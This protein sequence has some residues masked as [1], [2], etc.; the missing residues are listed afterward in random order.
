M[1]LHRLLNRHSGDLPKPLETVRDKL[2]NPIHDQ[3]NVVVNANTTRDELEQA[4][5]NR[6][7]V[8]DTLQE[9]R[10]HVRA[11]HKNPIGGNQT[12]TFKR[13]ASASGDI[14]GNPLSG[15][16]GKLERGE[17]LLSAILAK[18]GKS[19]GKVLSL[20]SATP[21]GISTIEVTF[22][23]TP[24]YRTLANALKQQGTSL[25]ELVR[26]G[27]HARAS[28]RNADHAHLQTALF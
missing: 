20:I 18:G 5:I 15:W 21:K 13:Y 14:P 4:P 10:F 22:D 24:D 3:Y 17:A 6:M 19:S 12:L 16:A 8:S 23:G 7:S 27:Y 26:H 25:D 9:Q 28:A 11:G 1:W 2:L